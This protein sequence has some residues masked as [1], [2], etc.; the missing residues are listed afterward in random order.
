VHAPGCCGSRISVERT[1][2]RITCASGDAGYT[3]RTGAFTYRC[4]SIGPAPV[5]DTQ[6][7]QATDLGYLVGHQQASNSRETV[8]FGR[9]RLSVRRVNSAAASN[10]ATSSV[11][12]VVTHNTSRQGHRN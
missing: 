4:R 3:S 8:A 6:T 10:C 9:V 7:E 2:Q 12:L 5:A 1:V 11:H